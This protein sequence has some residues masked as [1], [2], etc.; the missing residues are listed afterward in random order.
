MVHVFEQWAERW[1][2]PIVART[3][4]RFFT[5][6]ALSEKYLANLDSRGLGPAGRFR[7]GR[8]VCYPTSELVKWLAERSAAIPK[9]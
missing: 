8:K 1:P 3:E 9:K 5:G 2:A 6:G 4:I 7:V